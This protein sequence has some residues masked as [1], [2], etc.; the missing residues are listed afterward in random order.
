MGVFELPPY[1]TSQ[2]ECSIEEGC[3]QMGLNANLDVVRRPRR[4]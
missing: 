1:A 4:S 2:T 3:L